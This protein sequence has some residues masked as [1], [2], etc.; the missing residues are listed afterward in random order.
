MK[1]K[2]WVLHVSATGKE[3]AKYGRY[4]FKCCPKSLYSENIKDWVWIKDIQR[5]VC[6]RMF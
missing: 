3:Y 2:G 4:T 5:Y 6:N 1:H